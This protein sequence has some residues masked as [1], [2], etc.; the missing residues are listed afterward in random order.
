MTV[1]VSARAASQKARIDLARQWLKGTGVIAREDSDDEI[2]DDDI[3]WEWM[4]STPIINDPAT[5]QP[6]QTPQHD[7][8]SGNQSPSIQNEDQNPVD[9][10]QQSQPQSIGAKCGSFSCQVGDILLL[11]AEGQKAAWV[12]LAAEFGLQNEEMSVLIMW[13]STPSEVRSKTKKRRDF[14]LV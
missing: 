1:R 7:T 10:V 11:K 3:P 5:T 12:G 9:A 4:Y 8:Q 6:S 14:F 13:F 2:E